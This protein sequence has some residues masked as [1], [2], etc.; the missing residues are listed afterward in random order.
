MLLKLLL[1]AGDINVN[2]VAKSIES[3]FQINAIAQ[4]YN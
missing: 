1:A 4:L 2:F 3:D